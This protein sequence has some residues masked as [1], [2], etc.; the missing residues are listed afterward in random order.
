MRKRRVWFRELGFTAER[1]YGKELELDVAL[2]LLDKLADR[3]ESEKSKYEVVCRGLNQIE[4]PPFFRESL[5]DLAKDLESDEHFLPRLRSFFMDLFK[6]FCQ[7]KEALA[8]K[9]ETFNFGDTAMLRD[10]I[11]DK[12][13]PE[14]EECCTNACF[15]H[16]RF[17]IY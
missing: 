9:M 3:T 17:I 5:R 6:D 12:L 10:N 11:F 8:N 13:T 14:V 16:P 4:S 15:F 2:A 1:F 7:R